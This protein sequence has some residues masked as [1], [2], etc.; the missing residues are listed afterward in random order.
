MLDR[1]HGCGT[2]KGR[3]ARG[4][5]PMSRPSDHRKAALTAVKAAQPSA[6]GRGIRQGRADRGRAL[7][8]GAIALGIVAAGAIFATPGLAP[9][10]AGSDRQATGATPSVEYRSGLVITESAA[11]D[12]SE[13]TFDNRTGRMETTERTCDGGRASDGVPRG[14]LHRMDA[15]SKSFNR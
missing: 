10:T 7:I 11:G 12:C 2:P 3:R 8:I 9:K 4:R 13:R 6:P 5:R 14:T 15:I 1:L